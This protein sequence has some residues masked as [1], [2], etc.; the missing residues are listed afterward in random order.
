[1]LQEDKTTNNDDDTPVLSLKI[2]NKRREM[3]NELMKTIQNHENSLD[4][5]RTSEE[6]I[7]ELKKR[8]EKYENKKKELEEKNELLVERINE[9]IPKKEI[10]YGMY[11]DNVIDL[12]NKNPFVNTSIKITAIVGYTEGENVHKLDIM[13]SDGSWKKYGSNR[14]GLTKI[15]YSLPNDEFVVKVD[16]I[17]LHNHYLGS[18]FIFYTSKNRNLV[19]KG[20]DVHLNSNHYSNEKL[21]MINRYH[22]DWL[23]HF[24]AAR[25]IG[26]EIASIE[27]SYENDKVTRLIRSEIGWN[28]YVWTGGVRR[29]WDNSKTVVS[30]PWE[31]VRGWGSNDYTW[32]WADHRPFNWSNFARGNPNDMHYLE[33][34]ILIT[35]AGDWHDWIYHT[36]LPCVYS[37][38]V[39]RYQKN[40]VSVSSDEE[41]TGFTDIKNLGIETDKQY[42]TDTESEDLL[43]NLKTSITEIVNDYND[44]KFDL[45]NIYKQNVSII[46]KLNKVI[47]EIEKHIKDL[48]T[49]NDSV[50]DNQEIKEGFSNIGNNIINFFKNIFSN[51]KMKEGYESRFHDH[52]IN[53]FNDTRRDINDELAITDTIEYDENRSYM[54]ELLA[55]KQNTLGNVLMDYMVDDQEGSNVENVH[56]KI[57][58]DNADK[59]RNIKINTYYTKT[60]NEYIHILKVI[61]LLIILMIPIL[62]LNRNGIINKNI[63]L[64]LVVVTV[65]LGFLYVLKRLYLLT[66]KDDKDFDKI[67]I[68]Y[69]RQ[70]AQLVK[71][72]KMKYK[73]SPLKS[74]GIVCV[75]DECCDDNMIYD[76]LN[77]K[78]TTVKK[79]EEF[80]NYF[81]NLHKND[82]NN[83]VSQNN[84]HEN[85][86][87]FT[88]IREGY[89]N[90]DKKAQNF[91]NNLLVSSLNNSTND[92]FTM[93]QSPLNLKMF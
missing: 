58:Q 9:N 83:I 66:M 5:Y 72:G 47:K 81:E 20:P 38:I 29:R 54:A 73:S 41:I 64:I 86:E 26:W 28:S 57:S 90:T 14:H 15:Y 19:V 77:H 85:N 65:F 24:Y 37:K 22:S 61:I 87:N 80:S 39:N 46:I 17:K 25:S 8:K 13:L 11:S 23:S 69:D 12:L 6:K 36:R 55:K 45:E 33:S 53:V 51:N 42:W 7:E 68:P 82:E 34:N 62:I 59:L 21:Y 44:E 31:Q 30:W 93:K 4:K 52:M 76:N 18:A 49:L 50:P 88:P 32:R 67:K 1:M 40:T 78:C 84:L 2:L 35:G 16:L 74:M 70:T 75:G 56:E 43:K 63:T 10:E 79:I 48:R 71:R 89:I 60:Y 92:R 27:N 3:L 91:K